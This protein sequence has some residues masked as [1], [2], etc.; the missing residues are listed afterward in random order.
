M[1]PFL[2]VGSLT[3]CDRF[4]KKMRSQSEL[5]YILELTKYVRSIKIANENSYVTDI[6]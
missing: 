3:S 4:S 1:L 5:E 2:W 6:Q